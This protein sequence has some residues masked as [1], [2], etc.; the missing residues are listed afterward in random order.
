MNDLKEILG[1]LSD[2]SLRLTGSREAGFMGNIDIDDYEI[3]GADGAIIGKAHVELHTAVRGF[4]QS[5]TWRVMDLA[6]N[7]IRRS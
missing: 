1:L 4:K 6:G 3:L 2:Q 5:T 7:V